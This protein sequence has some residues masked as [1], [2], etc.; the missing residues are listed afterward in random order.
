M[1]FR[2]MVMI[3]LYARQKKRNIY[4]EQTYGLSGRRQG[5]DDLREQHRNMEITKC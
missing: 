5:W 3:T 2:K 4:I 1:E